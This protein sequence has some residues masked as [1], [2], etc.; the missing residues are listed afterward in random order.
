[1]IHIDK[2]LLKY[3]SLFT[4]IGGLDLG[5]DRA[6][7]HCSWQVEID[8]YCRGVLAK[9]WPNVERFEDVRTSGK[10]NLQ[11]VDLIAGGFPCQD[12]SNAGKRAGIEGP[13]SALWSE[14][15]RI[16]CELRPQYILV[17]NVSALLNRGISRVLGDLA[18]SRYDAEWQ[19]IPSAAI[20]ARHRRNRIFIVA[21]SNC[22]REQQPQGVIKEKWR[23]S[24]DR[25]E[26]IPH[27]K[28]IRLQG[29]RAAGKQ[30]TNTLREERV[31]N[32]SLCDCGFWTV[33][34][35]MGRVAHGVPK[36]MDRIK[37]LGNAVV[38]QVAEWIGK[39]IIDFHRR[40]HNI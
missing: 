20:G 8:S 24:G 3:G 14:F 37:G 1:M 13:K 35:D 32:R 36:G 31:F 5:L 26:A 33:E 6:G 2:G 23:W 18:Q 34:P 30:I 40:R 9:H 10:H 39:N 38:P 11:S 28:S 7:F 4:G 29:F 19:S 25:C 12:I 27:T 16:I 17:E 22:I 21:Y 15:Y